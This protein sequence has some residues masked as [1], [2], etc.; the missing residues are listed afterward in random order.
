MHGKPWR[1]WLVASRLGAGKPLTF[2][3]VYSMLYMVI[4][5]RASTMYELSNYPRPPT[6]W[7]AL[8]HFVWHHYPSPFGRELKYG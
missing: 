3:T 4:E 8:P 2:F 5:Y 7:A 1:V 6:T